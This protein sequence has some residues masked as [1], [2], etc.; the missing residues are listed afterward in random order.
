MRN[1]KFLI[2]SILIA[3]FFVITSVF[4]QGHLVKD[5]ARG[6]FA[7]IVK[8]G[9]VVQV[10]VLPEEDVDVVKEGVERASSQ[11]LLLENE[12]LRILL[13]F[14]ERFDF[15]GVGA[16][17]LGRSYDPSRARLI[18]NQ[19]SEH[20]VALGAPVVAG[21]GV[22]VGII[23]DVFTDSSVVR[24]L[25]DPKSRVAGRLLN[26][27]QSEGV[28]G[29]GHGIVVRMELVPRDEDMPIGTALVSSGLDQYVPRGLL[30]G[31]VVAVEQDTNSL[32]NR[33]IIETPVDYQRITQ[34]LIARQ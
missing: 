10:G 20:G 28:V 15:S 29:G 4:P 2:L 25:I 13:G 31:Y 24:L 11:D 32:F 30:V 19:G 21:D 14:T 18:V 33:A 26:T 9:Y 27:S 5:L 7:G 34:V 17:V 1:R 8:Y 16:D 23:E 6:F 12:E 3:G 22:L